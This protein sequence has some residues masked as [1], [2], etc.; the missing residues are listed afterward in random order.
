MSQFTFNDV[1]APKQNLFMPRGLNK[2]VFSNVEWVVPESGGKEFLQVTMENEE[3]A[4]LNSRYYFTSEKAGQISKSKVAQ[5][6]SATLD[7]NMKAGL[8]KAK[9]MF[10]S[11]QNQ[12]QFVQAVGKAL[13][14]NTVWAKVIGKKND[15]SGKIYNNLSDYNF[16]E[17]Y[18]EGSASPK[19]L[20]YNPEKD[21]DKIE[22]EPEA[23]E[24]QSQGSPDQMPWE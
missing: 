7:K 18:E 10:S 14:N 19:Y 8:E 5:L 15:Q 2:V 11:V 3:G 1:E 17:F 21:D 24:V 6:I 12:E 20:T 23:I 9:T 13:I 22:E 16:V 4:Q